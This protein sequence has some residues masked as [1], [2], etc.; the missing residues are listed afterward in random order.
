M[1]TYIVTYKYTGVRTVTYEVTVDTEDE[2]KELLYS[3][4]KLQN[5][6]TDK[7]KYINESYSDGGVE[8]VITKKEEEVGQI[9]E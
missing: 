6:D 1:K 7:I 2:V 8:R 5:E 4:D 3:Y 9:K